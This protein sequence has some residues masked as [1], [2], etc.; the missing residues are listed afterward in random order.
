MLHAMESRSYFQ[1]NALNAFWMNWR[2]NFEHKKI[3]RIFCSEKTQRFFLHPKVPNKLRPLGC[4]KHKDF[5]IYRKRGTILHDATIYLF[6]AL[7]V[8]VLIYGWI[9]RQHNGAAVWESFYAQEIANFIE[10]GSPGDEITLDI[11]H[12][13]KIASKNKYTDYESIIRIDGASQKVIVKLRSKGAS[14]Y[15][16]LNNVGVG[17]IKSELGASKALFTFKIVER[18]VPGAKNE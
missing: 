16:Y 17:S 2:G 15:H 10:Q 1:E 3:L 7:L 8:A 13:T 14:E 9:S 5:L 12:L 4:G 6:I 18:K 11:N